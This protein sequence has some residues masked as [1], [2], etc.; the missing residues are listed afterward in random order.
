MNLKS[1]LLGATIGVVVVIGGVCIYAKDV[2]KEKESNDNNIVYSKLEEKATVCE[3]KKSMLEVLSYEKKFQEEYNTINYEVIVKNTSGEKMDK[4]T[5]TL[6]EG[7]YELYN[8]LPDE[9]YKFIAYNSEEDL[10]LKVLSV[11]F[12]I[13]N[14]FP[15][16][17]SLNLE[18]IENKFKGSITNNG[19][20]DLYPG[21]IIYFLKDKEGYIIQKSI[22]YAGCFFEG[23][24]IS[25]N[26][27]HDFEADIPYND[28]TLDSSKQIV[29]EYSDLEFKDTNV[30]FF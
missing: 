18:N 14:Y 21:R 4:I 22:E 5:F 28:Y 9:E 29:V 23:L 2:K 25:P 12:E 6:G 24:V 27:K 19:Q 7:I 30:R 15:E 10:N 1:F 26:G 16:E 3:D 20:R 8:M 17:I 13:K 11:N